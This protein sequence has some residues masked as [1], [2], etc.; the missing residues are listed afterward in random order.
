MKRISFSFVFF[1]KR[2][3]LLKNGEA[4]IRLRITVKGIAVES[5]IKRSVIPD[6][7]NQ[8]SET[9]TGRD[10]KSVEIN[11]YIRML[12][13]KVL[14]I[15][16]ELELS[17]AHFTARLIMNKLYSAEEKQTL[18]SIFRKHND[19]IRKL[20]GIDYEK[21]TV[22]RYDSCC[23]YLEDMLKAQYGKDDVTLVEV[24][25][26]LIRNYEMHLKTVRG[27]QQNTVIRYM[28]CFKKVINQALAD[29][30]LTKDPF[31]GIRFT[32][33]EVIKDVLTK[34]EL[35]ILM[36][37]EFQIP[38]LEHVRDVF[39]FC[40]FCGVAYIDAHTLRAEH[41]VRDNKGDWWIKKTR[42]K[43]DIK[44]HVPLLQ[45]PMQ[46]LEKYKDD[47]DCQRT[48]LLL[49]ITSNQKMNH[50]LKEIAELCEIKKHL[51]THT[52][53]RTY[54]TT[55]CHE[56]GVAIEN[57]S[58]MLGHTDTRMTLHYTKIADTRIKKD[59]E[60]VRDIFDTDNVSIASKK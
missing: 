32:A 15:H 54:A 20:I 5:Q 29:G 19:D 60:Q 35:D 51:T 22:S 38:R 58:K 53:R 31:A 27:C 33:K 39:I 8:S 9:C 45:I 3:K 26:Q 37:R 49:P 55:V 34:D 41:I 30:M 48:G 57:I 7:W 42:E 2:T 44:F 12:K 18:I 14:T 21:R 50:Y 52:A 46:I 23:N 10:R 25:G 6:Q 36:N 24:D 13:L 43:T 4:P 16:R 56:S 28:K 40:C 1:I 11:E 59:M 47:P 17:G